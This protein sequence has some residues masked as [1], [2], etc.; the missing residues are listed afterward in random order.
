MLPARERPPSTGLE[1]R[2]AARSAQRRSCR[3]RKRT[4]APSA[5]LHSQVDALAAFEQRDKR[6][7]LHRCRR[8]CQRLQPASCG[9]SGT[10]EAGNEMSPVMPSPL[11]LPWPGRLA[12][13]AGSPCQPARLSLSQQCQLACLSWLKPPL[14]PVSHRIVWVIQVGQ[15]AHCGQAVGREGQPRRQLQEDR[16]QDGNCTQGLDPVGAHAAW[17]GRAPVRLH[18][19]IQASVPPAGG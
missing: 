19:L 15:P 12:G 8:L 6:G 5:C 2:C 9:G 13:P 11:Q 16:Q 10:T 7:T 14:S 3:T 18:Q 1:Q 4:Q 17:P